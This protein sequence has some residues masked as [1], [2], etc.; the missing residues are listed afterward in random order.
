MSLRSSRDLA[1]IV[2]TH[3]ETLLQWFPLPECTAE[4]VQQFIATNLVDRRRLLA[5][6]ERAQPGKV[7]DVLFALPAEHITPFDRRHLFSHYPDAR[8]RL[9][10]LAKTAPARAKAFG[11]EDAPAEK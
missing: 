5:A 2:T 3:P 8:Q 9:N 7:A 10:E 4:C 6:L 1:S 11:G